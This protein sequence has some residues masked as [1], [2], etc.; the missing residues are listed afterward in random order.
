MNA[1]YFYMQASNSDVFL[2]PLK[3]TI[4]G[5]KLSIF[6]KESPEANALEAKND[7]EYNYVTDSRWVIHWT[8]NDEM[9]ESLSPVCLLPT[10]FLQV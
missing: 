10:T 9:I 1:I 2:W 4:F 6:Y 7:Y 5:K 8:D 3:A